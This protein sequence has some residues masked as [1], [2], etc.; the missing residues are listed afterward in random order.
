MYGYIIATPVNFLFVDMYATRVDFIF[1]NSKHYLITACDMTT[2]AVCEV[3]AEQSIKLVDLALM[4]VW[5]GFA[6]SYTII[7]DK[8]SNL[9]RVFA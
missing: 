8:D 6:F 9:L 7:V 2:F 3:T 5:L 4:K 1:D